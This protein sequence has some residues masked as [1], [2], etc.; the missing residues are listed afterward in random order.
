MLR[1]VNPRAPRG[2]RKPRIPSW[3]D[4][5]TTAISAID[6]LVIHIL[7]PDRTQS[8]PLIIARVFM[9]EGS[10][11]WSGSVRPKQPMASPAAILGSH[12]FF[13]S[14]EPY[15]QIGNIESDPCTDT[16]LRSPESA[17][18]ISRQGRP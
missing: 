2:T 10:L 7:E 15:F 9:L 18:S 6:P 3:V 13:W 12:S 17:A 16:R 4:A 8:R 1:E 5:H 14:S 11:P